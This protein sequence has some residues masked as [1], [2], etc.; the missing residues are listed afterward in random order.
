MVSNASDITVGIVADDAGKVL[1]AKLGGL[2]GFGLDVDRFC[3]VR[4]VQFLQHRVIGAC[5]EHSKICHST[6]STGTEYF[7][8]YKVVRSFVAVRQTKRIRANE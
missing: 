1:N 6:I 2:T 8:H 3:A 5:R 4:C 7:S